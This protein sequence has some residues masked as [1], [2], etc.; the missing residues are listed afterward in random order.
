MKVVKV[1]FLGKEYEIQCDEKEVSK[2]INL[3]ARLSD[4]VKSSTDLVGNFS[5]TH[6]L[7]LVAISL[8]NK[9]NELLSSNKQ[10]IN[11]S[12]L[13]LEENIKIKKE[14]QEDVDIIK[15]LESIKNKVR[16]ITKNISENN[17]E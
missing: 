3:A 8:E 5:D 13:L 11:K 15:N 4:R 16:I 2:I 1:N 17:I 7:L 14:S 10:L 9:V 6:K 12:E